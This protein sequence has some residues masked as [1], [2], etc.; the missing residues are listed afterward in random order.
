MHIEKTVIIIEKH[1][2]S[3]LYCLGFVWFF[4]KPVI[5]ICLE[6]HVA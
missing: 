3:F 5:C 6:K 4:Y 1:C 2:L